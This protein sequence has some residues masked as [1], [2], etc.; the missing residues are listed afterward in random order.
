MRQRPSFRHL[1]PI[2]GR[3][4]D[5]ESELIM[6]GD[7]KLACIFYKGPRE[8]PSRD[9]TACVHST[10]AKSLQE[11]SISSIDSIS[12]ARVAGISGISSVA[13]L[14][15]LLFLPPLIVEHLK[16]CH[17]RVRCVRAHYVQ[18]PEAPLR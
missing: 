3:G 14:G 1:F 5:Q 7:P 18:I 6:C 13:A 10:S 15:R 8:I 9:V 2:G 4:E 16:Q 17:C 12:G 11:E